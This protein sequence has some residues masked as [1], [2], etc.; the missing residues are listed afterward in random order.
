MGFLSAVKN[1]QEV[2]SIAFLGKLCG[3]LMT[4]LKV[5]AFFLLSNIILLS[6]YLLKKKKGGV[7]TF[8]QSNKSSAN[9]SEML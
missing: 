7:L 6:I 5:K 8:P 9:H 4:L 2:N 1:L 3:F